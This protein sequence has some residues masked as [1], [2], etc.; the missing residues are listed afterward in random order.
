MICIRCRHEVQDGKYCSFCG[1]KQSKPHKGNTHRSPGDGTVWKTYQGKY[2]AV[3]RI[4]CHG[5]DGKARIFSLSK[6][7]PTREEAVSALPG[8]REE[9]LK[10]Y[11]EAVSA[12]A[13]P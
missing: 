6:V 7:F 2:R 13:Q 1:W 5:E 11:P 12:E 10:K 9:L 3:Q 4:S 8:L